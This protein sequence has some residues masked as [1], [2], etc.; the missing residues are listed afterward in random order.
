MAAPSK[1]VLPKA[2]QFLPTSDTKSQVQNGR[3]ALFILQ[4]SL[5]PTATGPVSSGWRP[6]HTKHD[7]LHRIRSRSGGFRL[8]PIVLPS[9]FKLCS[10]ARPFPR[11]GWANEKRRHPFD[12]VTGSALVCLGP[13][14]SMEQ[15]RSSDLLVPKG[16]L[17]PSSLKKKTKRSSSTS[18]RCARYNTETRCHDLCDQ[19]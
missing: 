2:V 15:R 19:R 6:Q 9:K 18:I 17:K 3:P 13:L 5:P 4:H 12:L 7:S 14:V 16:S 11:G 10:N 1:A 8:L